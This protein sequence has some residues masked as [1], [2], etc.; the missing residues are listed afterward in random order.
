MNTQE[1]RKRVPGNFFYLLILSF[2]LIIPASGEDYVIRL[3]SLD[4]SKVS[5]EHFQIKGEIVNNTDTE[6][7]RVSI[8]FK[9]YDPSGEVIEEDQILPFVNPIPPRGSSPFLIPIRYSRNME[10]DKITMHFIN[11]VGNELSVDPNG[12]SLEIKVPK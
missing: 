10:M 11:L 6:L 1:L 5:E 8:K 7:K 9:I 12:Y 4:V 3:K 2:L